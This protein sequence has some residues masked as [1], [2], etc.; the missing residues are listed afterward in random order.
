VLK[1]RP[2][3][4]VIFG[5]GASYG[6]EIIT[7]GLEPAARAERPPLTSG[8]FVNYG[9]QHEQRL[10]RPEIAGLIP[11]LH[12]CDDLEARLEA[13]LTGAV[14]TEDEARVA[15]QLRALRF[16]LR[17]VI[18]SMGQTW[19]DACGGVT[20]YTGLLWQIEAWRSRCNGVVN[21]VTFNYD[22]LLEDAVQRTRPDYV[23][24]GP[25]E[26]D[27]FIAHEDYRLY[28]VHGSVNWAVEIGRN[29][30]ASDG[31]S[32]D[33]AAIGDATSL[34]AQAIAFRDQI[35]VIKNLSASYS[36]GDP[37]TMPSLSVPTLGKADFACPSSHIAD[38]EERLP[39]SDYVLAVGWQGRDRHFDGLLR[40]TRAKAVKTYGDRALGVP[41][42]L[43]I[44]PDA[45]V[46][47]RVRGQLREA[48]A[49]GQCWPEDDGAT[50]QAFAV[51]VQAGVV[52]AWLGAGEALGQA[53]PR[54][55]TRPVA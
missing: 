20:A 53:P 35:H 17:N 10:L 25:P 19:R 28:K 6:S 26:L 50:H 21:L 41:H 46:V 29:Y 27:W 51:A 3:L 44:D 16:Y 45:S 8:L 47:D 39:Y 36:I 34:T 43:V 15:Q 38:L 48:I 54:A 23:V 12:G 52:G 33:G 30:S 14:G 5:A 42:V 49:G 4:T 18:W 7:V 32:A 2:I 24:T 13:I 37:V 9:V 11:Q 31:G 22:V 40:S 1:G 55:S